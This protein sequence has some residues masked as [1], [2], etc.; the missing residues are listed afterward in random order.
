MIT[1]ETCPDCAARLPLV[2]G[3]G[4][5]AVLPVAQAIATASAAA[6]ECL[7]E[8]LTA[9]LGEI[10]R[11]SVKFRNELTVAPTPPSYRTIYLGEHTDALLGSLCGVD[12]DQ[13]KRMR[14]G[15]VI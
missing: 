2:I 8:A 15:G 6:R 1:A 7:V 12:P 11:A 5:A 3:L 13:L 4:E 14:E 10:S 9:N